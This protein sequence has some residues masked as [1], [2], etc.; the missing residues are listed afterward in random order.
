MSERKGL[1]IPTLSANFLLI[2]L[3]C[4]LTSVPSGYKM[5]QRGL[6]SSSARLPNAARLEA[7]STR[8]EAQERER[9][10]NLNSC[11]P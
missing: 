8:S 5:K 3:V 9:K 1:T 6:S 7:K 11:I 2:G 4:W 10:M